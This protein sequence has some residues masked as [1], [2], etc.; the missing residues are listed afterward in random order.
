[1]NQRNVEAL[2]ELL[3][4]GW[5]YLRPPSSTVRESLSLPM[6]RRCAEMLAS[7]GVLA[8][9]S[10][11]DD[12]AAFRIGCHDHETCMCTAATVRSEL[13]RIAKGEV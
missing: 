11:T 2:T 7:Q 3:R 13:E 1:M 12:E 6:A 4:T 9:T 10:L 5:T 8:V